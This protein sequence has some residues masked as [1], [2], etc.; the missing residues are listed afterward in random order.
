LVSSNVSA[1]GISNNLNGYSTT[2][3]YNYY[4]ISVLAMYDQKRALKPSVASSSE[5]RTS[6]FLIDAVLSNLGYSN[7]IWYVNESAGNIGYYPELIVFKDNKNSDFSVDSKNSI[8][9]NISKGFGTLAQ[10]FLIET[11]EEMN[12]LSYMVSRGN[13]YA[14]YYFKVKDGITELNLGDFQPIGNPTYPFDGNFNGNG[15]NFKLSINKES[16][17]NIGLFGASRTGTIEN[18]SVSGSIIGRNQV[19][20]IVG[21]QYSGTIKNVYSTAYVVASGTYGG[22]IV[23]Y[24][25]SSSTLTLSYFRGEVLANSYAA[26]LVGGATSSNTISYSYSSG[27]VSS[28]AG[29]NGIVNNLDTYGISRTAIFYDITVIANYVNPNKNKPSALASTQGLNS[30]E[31]FSNMSSRLGNSFEFVETEDGFAYYPQLKAFSEHKNETIKNRSKTSVQVNVSLGL[32]TELFPFI[33]ESIEDIENLKDMIKKGNNFQ[34][35]YFKMADGIEK[36]KLGNFEPIGSQTY[37]FYGSFDGNFVEFELEIDHPDLDNQGLFGYFGV[38]TIKNLYVSGSVKGK[39]NVGSVV[40]YQISGKVMNVYNLA[41]I[42]GVNQVGGIVGQV[43]A[44][45]VEVAYNQGNITASTNY[46]GGIVGYLG[47]NSVVRNTYNRGEILSN[48][49]AAGLVGG[50]NSST[51]VTYSYSAGLVSSNSYVDGVVNNLDTYGI[52]R[53][54]I[55]Y[56]TSLLVNYDQPKASKPPTTGN[57]NGR[58]SNQLL[59]SGEALGLPSNVWYFEPKDGDFAYYPQLLVFANHINESIR[60]DSKRSVEVDVSKGLGTEDFPFLIT[61]KADMDELS[62]MV[63]DGNTYV[64]FYFKVADEISEID[65]EDFIP[66]GTTTYPFDGH[67]NGNGV[68]FILDINRTD[69]NVGLFGVSRTGTIENLSVSGSITGRNQVGSVVG[70]QLSGTVRNVYSTAKVHATGTYAGGIIGYMNSGTT[71]TQSYFRGE[72]TAQTYAAG[73][74][75]G[76]NSSNKITH[77]YSAAKVASNTTY[78]HGLVNNIDTYGITRT[79]LYYDITEIANYDTTFAYKPSAIA[80]NEGLNSGIF[81]TEMANRLGGNFEYVVKNDEFAYYPQLKVFFNHEDEKIKENSTKSVIV[82]IK[83]GLGTEQFPFILKTREDIENLKRMIEKGNT[84]QGFYFIM[85]ES[86]EK[87]TLDDFTPIGTQTRPFYGSFDGNFVEFEI[88]IHNSTLD[89]QGLFGYFG[90]GTIKNLKVSGIVQGRN[91][92][93]GVVGY[94]LSG[95]VMNVYNFAK[96]EGTNQVAGIVG[97]LANGMV[98]NVYNTGSVTG[99]GDYAGGI[100]GYQGNGTVQNTYNR[101]E[102]ISNRYVAGIV[103]GANSYTK[104]INSYSSALVSGAS[105]VNGVVNNRDTYST[106]RTNLYYDVSILERYVPPKGAKPSTTVGGQGLAKTSMFSDGLKN[107]G[108]SESTWVFLEIDGQYAYYPQLRVF[109]QHEI[110]FIKNDSMMSVRTNPFL[111]DGTKASPYIISTAYDMMNLANSINKDYQALDTYYMVAANVAEFDLSK[112]QFKPIGSKNYPFLG[113]FDG[114]YANFHVNLNLNED[115]VGLFGAIGEGASVKNLSVTGSI[116]GNSYTGSIV[117]YNQGLVEQVYSTATV[118][119]DSY[120]G[121]LVGRNID[122]LKLAYYHGVLSA[123]GQYVGGIAGYNSASIHDVY[124]SAKVS[125][126]NYVGAILGYNIGNIGDA[127]FNYTEIEYFSPENGIKPNYAVSNELNKD[128]VRGLAKEIMFTLD[129]YTFDESEW[130]TKAT[131]GM[132]NYYLQLKGFSSNLS[133]VVKNNSIISVRTVRFAVG[134]GDQNYPYLIRHEEDMRILS[135]VSQEDSLEGLYFKVMDGVKTLDLSNPELGFLPIGPSFKHFKGHFDG[136]GVNI[137]LQM[138]RST[139]DYIGLF[140][141]IENSTIK[142]LHIEGQIDGRDYVGVIG[143]AVKSQ[144]NEVFVNTVVNGRSYV[145]GITG[146]SDQ[147]QISNSY[148]LNQIKGSNQYIGG[149]V[150][151]STKTQIK[152]VFNYGSVYGRRVVGGIVGDAE[153]NTNIEFAYNRKDVYAEADYAGGITAYLNNGYVG[154]VY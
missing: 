115:Y 76:A 91:N 86:V 22:G 146:Y 14:S 104:I 121:G 122:T 117:G 99:N 33:L 143:A 9:R 135:L 1:A 152:N 112:V 27:E 145:G 107:R 151:Y 43:G 39:N 88:S 81:F 100:V 59:Y 123:T 83:G 26:G 69:D 47:S 11:V 140:G 37:P 128:T 149:L 45:T 16:L 73:L 137:I 49:Y 72:V 19:G 35:F 31:F 120:V 65:L 71:L 109:A 58:T 29:V 36:L 133:S 2:R 116:K 127:Y 10:P 66:I 125:G 60:K 150:G 84:F 113:H 134:S 41:D 78:V 28:N 20:S 103:G 50:A 118:Q 13:S 74:V 92:V 54:R 144:I 17:D 110:E 105:Y 4:D 80:T 90:V 142:N 131:S 5:G 61:S 102:I 111:G 82:D 62:R 108:F 93:A 3:S 56:D 55:Y 7:T 138:N 79:N 119:G 98:Q 6:N 63:R 51:S 85:D 126:M 77:S 87:M 25:N 139:S 96:I 23:G 89:N 42:E 24:M 57:A 101:G 64:G 141:Y 124:T 8:T 154:N 94:Q 130:E 40:G 97:Q 53:S 132:Y 30:G 67:F 38:G 18:L 106:T 68:N 46:A 32:G 95:T 153:T 12:N 34:G 148:N 147:T 114:N 129:A 75:G 70:Q 21:Q 15:V 52:T 136:N 48:S 44:A